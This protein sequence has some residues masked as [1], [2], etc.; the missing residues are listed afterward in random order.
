M[1]RLRAIEVIAALGG[2]T[3][4]GRALGLHVNT[5]SGW[6]RRKGFVPAKHVN[7][8]LATLRSAGALVVSAPLPPP[9][10]VSDEVPVVLYRGRAVG[11]V[12]EP[13]DQA[14]DA[15]SRWL[16]LVRV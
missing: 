6:R 9:V 11:L 8:V 12:P 1:G 16:P 15:P 5:V 7:R 4:A 10:V 13:V 2:A 3:S 14:E